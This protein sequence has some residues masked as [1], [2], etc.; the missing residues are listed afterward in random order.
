MFVNYDN[1]SNKICDILDNYEEYYNKIYNNFD[2]QK[3]DDI[4]SNYIKQFIDYVNSQG[5][6]VQ[7]S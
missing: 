3:N 5:Y 2:I 4:L 1:M 6:K 7:T